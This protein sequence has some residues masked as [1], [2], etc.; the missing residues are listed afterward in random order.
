MPSPQSTRKPPG[1]KPLTDDELDVLEQLK[2]PRVAAGAGSPVLAQIQEHLRT[3]KA[4]SRTKAVFFGH[5]KLTSAPGEL[6]GAL[7]VVEAVEAA[8]EAHLAVLRDATQM[9]DL[10]TATKNLAN[11]TEQLVAA[12]RLVGLDELLLLELSTLADPGAPA[13]LGDVE[14]IARCTA[15]A[16]ANAN[17]YQAHYHRLAIP[18]HDE[19]WDEDRIRALHVL[20]GGGPL[21]DAAVKAVIADVACSRCGCTARI[22]CPG[23]CSWASRHPNVCTSCT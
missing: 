6:N 4:N 8:I 16:L 22:A 18:G 15:G 14:S 11:D 19:M 10:V 9:L 5:S 13:V 2:L 7:R 3:S 20:A 23:G 17:A 12:L 1:R 21:D